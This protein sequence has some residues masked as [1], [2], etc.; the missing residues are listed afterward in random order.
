M[1]GVC[2]CGLISIP[3]SSLLILSC[4]RP[5]KPLGHGWKEGVPPGHQHDIAASLGCGASVLCWGK[6]R[7]TFV[8]MSPA[9]LIGCPWHTAQQGGHLQPAL[10][11]GLSQL[12]E[13]SGPLS[14]LLTPRAITRTT[15]CPHVT[16]SRICPST[17]TLC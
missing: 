14:P 8:P 16:P 11:Q 5:N 2:S 12:T 15:H 10:L 17:G 13:R 6:K 9:G 1:L 3:Q 7:W 4:W